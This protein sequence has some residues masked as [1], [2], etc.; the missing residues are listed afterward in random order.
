MRRESA[1][2]LDVNA[3]DDAGLRHDDVDF[4]VSLE[5]VAIRKRVVIPAED[6]RRRALSERGGFPDDGDK[7]ALLI[8][9]GEIREACVSRFGRVAARR[10]E[11]RRVDALN[12]LIRRTRVAGE[13]DRV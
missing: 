6:D 3:G 10:R 8:E 11:A 1:Y 4:W 7:I 5:G 9:V 13:G 12:R 2:R